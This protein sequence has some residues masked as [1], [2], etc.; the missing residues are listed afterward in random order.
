MTVWI[1]FEPTGYL[2]RHFTVLE[3]EIPAGV[4]ANGGARRRLGVLGREAPAWQRRV[5]EEVARKD[6]S[7][8][9]WQDCTILPARVVAPRV[10]RKRFAFV[11]DASSPEELEAKVEAKRREIEAARE[12]RHARQVAI[13]RA[14]W[15]RVCALR[16]LVPEHEDLAEVI[17]TREDLLRVRPLALTEDGRLVKVLGLD[18]LAIGLERE[19]PPDADIIRL[20]RLVEVK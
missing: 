13:A 3:G 19:D 11:L 6:A 14:V 17:K 16:R 4:G 5:L 20:T 7:K 12:G 1:Y 9:R 8:D 15:P 10:G 18:A 2:E